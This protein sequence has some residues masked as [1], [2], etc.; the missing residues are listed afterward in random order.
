[1]TTTDLELETLLDRIPVLQGLPRTVTELPGG[2][3]NQNLHISTPTHDVVVRLGA[4]V[5][6][7]VNSAAA[8]RGR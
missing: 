1:M 7:V 3:T 8:T 5:S 6:S 2:L 4:E